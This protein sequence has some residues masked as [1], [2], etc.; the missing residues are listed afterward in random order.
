[1]PTTSSEAPARL[2]CLLETRMKS[3]QSIVIARRSRTALAHAC[4]AM[5]VGYGWL[6]RLANAPHHPE[7]LRASSRGTYVYSTQE[8]VPIEPQIRLDKKDDRF[9]E[10]KEVLEGMAQ[11]QNLA[12]MDWQ[13]FEHLIRELLAKEFGRKEGSEVLIIRASRDRGVDA[14]IFDPDP[15]SLIGQSR[16]R[17]KHF[18]DAH[19][20]GWSANGLRM[21][22]GLNTL[23]GQNEEACNH[24]RPVGRRLLVR[25]NRAI[26]RSRYAR[27]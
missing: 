9:V 24:R 23:E 2:V 22:N 15:P 27:G 14:V 5:D 13:D 26:S 6:R 21:P 12:T 11:G 16:V 4:H 19:H 10:G 8:I 20:S 1:M 18:C 3:G 25:S 17:D 7:P